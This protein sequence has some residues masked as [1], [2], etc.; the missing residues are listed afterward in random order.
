MK[1]PT[2]IAAANPSALHHERGRRIAKSSG[3]SID[4]IV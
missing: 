3:M 2:R 1:M 4:A